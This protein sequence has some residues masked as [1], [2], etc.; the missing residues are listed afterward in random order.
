MKKLVSSFENYTIIAGT[1]EAGRGCI[2]GPVVAAACILP[3]GY[4]NTLINDSKQISEKLREE[5]F[6]EICN[7]SIGYEIVEISA[8][9]I[10]EINILNASILGMQEAAKRL[11]MHPDILLVDGNRFKSIDGIK[12]QTVIKGDSIYLQ[13]AAAS[14]LAKVHRDRLMRELDNA[15]PEYGWAKN[16]GYP[17]PF[18][19]QQ[20]NKL[21]ITEHHR[22]SYAPVLRLLQKDLFDEVK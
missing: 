2:A 22:K 18:H 14:I 9:T 17:T 12:H 8:E 3:L 11:K 4:E 21:D 13:I 6:E 16:K 19:I 5:L 20:I 1:D 7:V 10:D 15:Y